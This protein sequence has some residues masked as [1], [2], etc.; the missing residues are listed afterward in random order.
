MALHKLRIDHV[1]IAGSELE[2]LRQRFERIGLKTEYGGPH[3][4]QITHMD[5]L[6]FDDG[7]Y[8]ELISRMDP[9]RESPWW[10]QH[11]THD[12]GPCAWAV[13]VD[14][15]DREAE[16]LAT[17]GITVRGPEYYH[18]RR[19]DGILV[20]WDLAFPGDYQPGAKLP[21]LISDR[22]PR[23][24]RVQPSASVAGSELGGLKKVI[25]G[26]QN[27]DE[28][29]DLFRGVYDWS[30]PEVEEQVE[31][32]ARLADFVEEEVILAQPVEES[33][34]QSRLS[35]YGESPC[36]YLIGSRNLTET[37]R[38]RELIRGPDWFQH[39]VAWFEREQLGGT[40]L[41]VT[42]S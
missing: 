40:R 11:I 7:S 34:L 39:E 10:H 31:F 17:L 36:G 13:Q 2:T 22:T 28:A 30:A 15:I 41:G 19:P 3:S 29:V 18:R 16:R 33:W 1:T 32:G 23:S 38:K 5:L 27:L 14:D 42:G 37:W 20:E 26:V 24:L 4:N 12:G 6:G 9:E 35:Q 8:I 25:L 21:F